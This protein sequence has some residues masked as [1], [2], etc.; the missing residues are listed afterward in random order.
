M[1][2][3]NGYARPVGSSGSS[4]GVPGAD[5][6]YV[7]SDNP[8]FVWSC[9]GEPSGGTLICQGFGDSSIAN[10]LSRP[11][12][13]AG[14]K[15]GITGVCHQAANRILYPG[16]VVV[17]F[18]QGYWASF[19]LYGTYG[20]IT[21]ESFGE[22]RRRKEDCGARH[23]A[24]PASKIESNSR[25]T[26]EKIYNQRII[27]LYYKKEYISTN[28]DHLL[29]KELEYM[30]E[31]RLG[32]ELDLQIINL[33]KKQ[34]ADL[35]KE[36]ENKVNELYNGDISTEKYVKEINDIVGDTLISLQEKLGKNIY[37][38]IFELSSSKESFILIDPEIAKNSLK[39]N[40]N[41]K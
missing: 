20:D 39:I 21:A 41:H 14:I 37:E 15:Y 3:L 5:H 1:S 2:T 30:L 8:H 26:P 16:E 18:A 33:V 40:T 13:E 25:N 11:N 38:K 4:S 29:K 7:T 28:P 27:D 24:S 35:L 9:F 6:T 36:K 12:S 34:R 32:G 17:S 10:C 23:V 19:Y 31:F 22:W